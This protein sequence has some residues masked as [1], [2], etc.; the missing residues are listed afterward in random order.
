MENEKV[1]IG[2]IKEALEAVFILYDFMKERAEDGLGWDDAGALI[3]EVVQ[4]EEFR[5]AIVDGFEGW[6]SLGAEAKDLDFSEG[7]ELV[8]FVLDKLK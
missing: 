4:N 2:E 7:V 6:Q 1:G 8:Q 5:Q 3:S